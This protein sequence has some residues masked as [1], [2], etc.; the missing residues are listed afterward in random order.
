M[1][2]VLAVDPGTRKCGLAVVSEQGELLT[3]EVVPTEAVVAHLEPL[4]TTHRPEVLLLG[5][6]TAMKKVRRAIEASG[7]L[8]GL[9][10]KVVDERHTTELARERYFQDHPPRGLWKLIPRG[11]QVPNEPYDDYAA[12]ILAE[13]WLRQV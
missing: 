3:H 13:A 11:L 8:V 6:G 1:T 7:L 5:N 2:T 12:V 10:V 4:L 9:A